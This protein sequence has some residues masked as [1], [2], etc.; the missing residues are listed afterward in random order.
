MNYRIN[1]IVNSMY[2]FFVSSTMVVLFTLAPCLWCVHINHISKQSTVQHWQLLFPRLVSF[3][4]SAAK[5][6]RLQVKVKKEEK[7]TG[8]V[9][10]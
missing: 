9:T 4:Y 3:S 7:K 2:D 1:K 10:I 6:S 5:R 8:L